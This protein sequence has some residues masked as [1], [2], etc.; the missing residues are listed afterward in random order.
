MN[1]IPILLVFGS[2]LMPICPSYAQGIRKIV[3]AKGVTYFTNEPPEKDSAVKPSP[4]ASAAVTETSV[5]PVT[6]QVQAKKPEDNP[7]PPQS[8][9]S[10]PAK[11]PINPSQALGDWPPKSLKLTPATIP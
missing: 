8:A 4:V 6:S 10:Q 1:I 7:K 3:D 2:L 9:T 11:L 5:A